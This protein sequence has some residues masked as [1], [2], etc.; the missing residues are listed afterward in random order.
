MNRLK[1][2]RKESCLSLRKLSA[3]TDI[4]NT[5]LS[6]L[7]TG[8]RPFRQEH[9]SILTAFFNVT[10]D[11]LLGRSDYGLNVFPQFGQEEIT[12]TESE[13]NRLKAHITVSQANL[14][15]DKAVVFSM[16]TPRETQ[17]IAIPRTCVYRELKGALGDYDMGESL[18]KKLDE[19]KS[20]MTSADLEKTIRFIEEYILK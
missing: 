3:C 15:N 19:L 16:D 2:L 18:S 17:K 10:S 6:Y 9:I 13:Y 8:T 4:S 1:F 5:V 14:G 12:L 7:E 20:H 11:Y